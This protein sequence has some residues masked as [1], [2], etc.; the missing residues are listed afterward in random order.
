M[1]KAL[2]E[3]IR[4]SKKTLNASQQE[5]IEEVLRCYDTK[6]GSKIVELIKAYNQWGLKGGLSPARALECAEGNFFGWSQV[7]DYICQGDKPKL[8]QVKAALL[9]K[10]TTTGPISQ[11][12]AQTVGYDLDSQP[13]N[14][15]IDQA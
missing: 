4:E 11:W 1:S 10:R 8:A 15:R 13:L 2:V 5:I 12:Y 6:D 7:A 9:D 3:R 14:G